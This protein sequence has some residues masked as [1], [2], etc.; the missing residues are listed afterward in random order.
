MTLANKFASTS[1]FHPLNFY[2][3]IG[4]NIQN[5]SNVVPRPKEIYNVVALLG[6]KLDGEQTEY[7]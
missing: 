4:N 7:M 5:N 1:Y 6:S 2:K 3:K